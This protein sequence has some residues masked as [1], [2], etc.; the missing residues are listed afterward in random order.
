MRAVHDRS[1]DD[2]PDAPGGNGDLVIRPAA[3][4]TP[5]DTAGNGGDQ[6]G[7][8]RRQELAG[9]DLAHGSWRSHSTQ[10]RFSSAFS[11]S[12]VGHHEAEGRLLRC[13]ANDEPRRTR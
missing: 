3:D 11:W 6:P 1:P 8:D 7:A 9:S 12:N 5:D 10:V 13:S 4:Q 2:E